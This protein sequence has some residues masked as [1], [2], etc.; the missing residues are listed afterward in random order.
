MICLLSLPASLSQRALRAFYLEIVMH[1][2]FWCLLTKYLQISDWRY[3]MW[4]CWSS[5]QNSSTSSKFSPMMPQLM[6]QCLGRSNL[7]LSFPWLS[8][9]LTTAPRGSQTTFEKLQRRGNRR[10]FHPVYG[11]WIWELTLKVEQGSCLEGLNLDSATSH[12]VTSPPLAEQPSCKVAGEHLPWH[13]RAPEPGATGEG[14]G[15][16]AAVGVNRAKSKTGRADGVPPIDSH[17]SI[18]VDCKCWHKGWASKAS[19]ITLLMSCFYC[20]AAAEN[21]RKLSASVTSVACVLYQQEWFKVLSVD[22]LAVFTWLLG[23]W[24]V[25]EITKSFVSLIKWELQVQ[26]YRASA[27]CM[28]FKTELIKLSLPSFGPDILGVNLAPA[29][30]SLQVPSSLCWQ[31]WQTQKLLLN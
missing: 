23:P 15:T 25:S 7:P 18:P 19:Q 20:L 26:K 6:A 30:S 21:K 13:V 9:L 8:P 1:F 2:D 24:E 17:S 4:L 28:A 11:C 29:S 16:T 27:K 10:C 3:L 5:W 31:L 14:R 12:L 22:R